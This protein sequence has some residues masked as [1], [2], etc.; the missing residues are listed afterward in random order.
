VPNAVREDFFA[1]S[2]ATPI[3]RKVTLVNVGV[4]GP[5]KRQIELLNVA[6]RLH[7]Q[8]FDFELLFVG[9][10]IAENTYTKVFFEKL[11]P[12]E[13]AGFARHIGLQPTSELIKILDASAAMVHFPPEESFGLVV[14]EAL[15]RN[16][17]LFAARVG[18]IID[19]AAGVPEAELF[20]RDDW[21]GLTVAIANWLRRGAPP[22]PEIAPIMRQRYHPDVITARHVEIYQQVLAPNK[23]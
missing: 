14:G 8:G 7:E 15:A 11:K 20:E 6:R 18:G 9:A 1:P 12:I 16:L 3:R 5:G 2:S 19:I 23:K 22:P 10:A 13:D 17:K 21:S 4:I